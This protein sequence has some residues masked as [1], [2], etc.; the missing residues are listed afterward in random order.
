MRMWKYVSAQGG[1]EKNL[2]LHSSEPLPK[3]TVNQHLVQVLA[4]GLN[5]VDYKPA[6]AP[7]IGSLIVKKPATPGFDIAGRI[8][9]PADGSNLEPGQLVYGAASTNPLAGGGLAEFIA[10]LRAQAAASRPA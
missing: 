9:T 2:Q 6:E 8:I 4:V 10:A 3:P 7:F 5:P 1:L